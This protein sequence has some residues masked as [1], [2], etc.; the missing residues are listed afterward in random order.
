M[1]VKKQKLAPYMGQLTGTEL[2]KEHDKALYCHPIHVTTMQRT[3]LEIAG[4]M[5]YKLE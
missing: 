4:W 3:S 5:S 2:R 1:Q